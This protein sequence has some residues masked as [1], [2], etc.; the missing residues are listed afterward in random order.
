MMVKDLVLKPRPPGVGDVIENL[1]DRP[2]G[3][4]NLLFN[5]VGLIQV[6]ADLGNADTG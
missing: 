1:P 4:G 6:I 5:M 3:P 2:I